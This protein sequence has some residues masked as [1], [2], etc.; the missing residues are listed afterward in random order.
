[1]YCGKSGIEGYTH[2]NPDNSSYN[3]LLSVTINGASTCSTK[4][5]TKNSVTLFTHAKMY[6]LLQ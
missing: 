1:M 6:S 4:T 5:S 2:Y 3:P